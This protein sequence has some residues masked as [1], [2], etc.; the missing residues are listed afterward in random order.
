MTYLESKGIDGLDYEFHSPQNEL[1]P[2]IVFIHGAGGDR[3]QWDSQVNFLLE[4][5]YGTLAISLNNHGESLSALNNSINPVSVNQTL[6]DQYTR[7]V[8]NIISYLKLE[9]YSL[10]GHSMGGAIVLN[11][12]L[13]IKKQE[14]K[15]PP[16]LPA[17]IFLMSTGAKLNVAPIFFD[18]LKKDYN[19]ALKLMSKFSYGSK[20]ELQIKQ[21]N[22]E[23]LTKNGWHVLYNDLDACRYF[24]VRKD[25]R[26]IDIPTIILCGDQDQMTPPKFSRYLHENI[27]NS[28]LFLIEEAGHF[29]FQEAPNQVNE[30]IHK[31][32]R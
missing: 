11:Y 20:A 23:I 16:P 15:K 19:E 21:K 2:N 17:V 24:D 28:E 12:V 9:S 30:I 14:F 31:S 32:L 7:E 10:V 18:L 1:L 6:I 27:S 8:I 29:I 13:F 22:Q 25:L 5:G 3:T 26:L 4:N